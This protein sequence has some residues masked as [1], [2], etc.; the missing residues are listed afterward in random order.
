M[1]R[2]SIYYRTD[3]RWKKTYNVYEI[4]FEAHCRIRK[5]GHEAPF[6]GTKSFDDPYYWVFIDGNMELK[7]T[8]DYWDDLSDFGNDYE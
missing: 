5:D 6:D 4:P 8:S 7:L 1:S 3:A 2:R